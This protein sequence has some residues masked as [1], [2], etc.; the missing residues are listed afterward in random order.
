MGIELSEYENR[1][2]R[3]SSGREHRDPNKRC[4]ANNP[5]GARAY[6]GND[7]PSYTNCGSQNHVLD[8]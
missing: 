7:D 3:A 2:I 6:Y 4:F 1:T 8:Y 5:N